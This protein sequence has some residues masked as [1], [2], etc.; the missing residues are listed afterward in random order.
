MTKISQSRLSRVPTFCRRVLLAALPAAS[1]LPAPGRAS[2]SAWAMPL[3]A[4]D[5]HVHVFLDRARFPLAPRRNYT[6]S[7]ATVDDLRALHQR[8]GVARVVI[9]QPTVYGIDNSA[10]VEGLR[11]YGK[12]SARG[13]AVIDEQTSVAELR[14]LHDAGVRGVRINI[15][16]RGDPAAFDPSPV[17][18]RI[19][20][21]V[22][23]IRPLGWHL[24]AN[25]RLRDIGL[26][27]RLLGDLPVPVVLDHFGHASAAHGLDQPGMAELL[28][29]L[30]AG[31][32]YVKLSAA[33]NTSPQAPSD[34]AI[35]VLA[36]AYYEANP[37]AILWGSN[38]PHPAQ[39]RGDPLV[40][41]PFRM[42]DDAAHLD[43][44]AVWFPNDT[45]RYRILVSNP[46]T[47]FG[48]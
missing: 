8:L 31:R 6:P 48:F 40:E 24:Q 27:S 26:L 7:L 45:D 47:L 44:L 13:I 5:C 21:V 30:R 18:A 43:Q 17:A 20:A 2:V 1:V 25:L 38:W 22:D 16:V 33:Y 46:A 3:G 19:A 15:G 28:T 41:T 9:V 10:L 34:P 14:A 23:R 35:G 37:A 4:T 32:T 29:L 12:A 36:R 39:A 11:G 42:V